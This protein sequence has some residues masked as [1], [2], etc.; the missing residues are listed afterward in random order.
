[1]PWSFQSKV[2]RILVTSCAEAGDIVQSDTMTKAITGFMK[3]TV[4]SYGDR[5]LAHR[6]VVLAMRP[7]GDAGFKEGK[8]GVERDAHDREDQQSGEH[9][10]HVEVGTSD[11]H[12]VADAAVRRHGF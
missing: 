1:M 11:H 9:Q 3:D 5:R 7:S 8:H 2:K 6:K 10:R 4:D 12:H